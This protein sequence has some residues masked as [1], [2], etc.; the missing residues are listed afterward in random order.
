MSQPVPAYAEIKFGGKLQG[1]LPPPGEGHFCC[2]IRGD[3]AEVVVRDWLPPVQNPLT[4]LLIAAGQ[5]RISFCNVFDVFISK[6]D[7]KPCVAVKSRYEQLIAF[8]F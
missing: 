1:V 8:F 5:I 6:L 7:D 3:P 4:A 2:F